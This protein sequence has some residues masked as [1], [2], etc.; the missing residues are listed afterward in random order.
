MSA[1]SWLYLYAVALVMA[2]FVHDPAVLAGGLAGALL[3]SGKKRWRLLK[4]T[5]LAILAF[6][7]TVSA[8]YILVAHWQGNFHADYL[9][10]VNLRV[11]LMVFLGFW[12]TSRIN[13]LAT[14]RG[15]AT[16]ELLAT[17]A[18]SQ[19]RLYTRI[20]SDFRLA[21]ISRNAAQPRLA[22]QARNAAALGQTL[23]DKSLANSTE[24]ALAMRSRGTFDN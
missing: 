5:V 16:L 3:F 20:I 15:W 8:G 24:V 9:L 7:L 19:I 4:R 2:S 21:F 1:R 14:L 17:L 10:L 6:N 23:L 11:L 22:D 18:M 13:L 12:F